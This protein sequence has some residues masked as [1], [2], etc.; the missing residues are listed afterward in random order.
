[1][2]KEELNKNLRCYG[3]TGICLSCAY[4]NICDKILPMFVKPRKCGGPFY[5]DN[6]LILKS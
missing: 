1:M 4:V 6:K 2:T 5:S 3:K